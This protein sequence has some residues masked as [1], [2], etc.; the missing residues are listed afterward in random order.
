M[1]FLSQ[2][3]AKG[4]V[5]TDFLTEHPVPRAIEFY[6]DL[7]NEVAEVCLTQTFFEGQVCQLFFDGASRTGPRGNVV[8]G[9]G[10]VFVS[11]QNYIIPRTFSLTEPCSNNIA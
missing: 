11:P 2:K 6:E 7:P 8:E 5:V 1:Q 3:A 9:V 4:Q 10:V